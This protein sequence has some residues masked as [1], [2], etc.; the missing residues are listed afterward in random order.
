M[1]TSEPQVTRS[2]PRVG[3]SR[4]TRSLNDKSIDTDPF[5]KGLRNY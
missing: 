1:A 3:P 5:R 2:M 4:A